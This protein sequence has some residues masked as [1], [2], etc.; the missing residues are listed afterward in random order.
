ML[1][2]LTLH[3]KKKKKSVAVMKRHKSRRLKM[4]RLRKSRTMSSRKSHRLT[5]RLLKPSRQRLSTPT[6]RMRTTHRI[7]ARRLNLTSCK[8]LSMATLRLFGFVTDVLLSLMRTENQR[9]RR[10]IFLLRISCAVTIIRL[11]TLSAL[12]LFAMLI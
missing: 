3:R 4:P 8:A 1:S 10:S 6:R 2:V 9:V 7:T 11:I 5:S 12:P